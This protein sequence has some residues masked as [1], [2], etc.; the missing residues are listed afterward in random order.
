MPIQSRF[1]LAVVLCDAA[2]CS[3]AREP[4]APAPVPVVRDS[5]SIAYAA[6]VIA[7]QIS[8]IFV[9]GTFNNWSTT[10]TP[11]PR[12]ADGTWLVRLTAAGPQEY[13]F[14]I[15]GAWI[16]DMCN[17]RTWGD[18][19]KD[20]W[21]D[22]GALGCVSDGFSGRNAVIDL[23]ASA[24][25]TSIGFHHDPLAAAQLSIAAGQLSV[26]FTAHDSRVVSA[27]LT[28]T[29]QSTPM[30]KQLSYRLQDVWRG[31]LREGTTSYSISVVT[32]SGTQ[33]FG[34][35][36]VPATPFRAVPWVGS[37]VGYQIFP[38]RFWNGD[39]SNDSLTV[40]TDEIQFVNPALRGAPPA[41]SPQWNGDATSQLC[42]HQYYGGDLQGII[43]KLAY[44]Q[45]LGVTL[46][47]LNPIFSSGSAHGYDTWD[48]SQV[49][50]SFGTE[51]VLRTL[52]QQAHARGMRVMFDFV[53]NHVGLGA[54]QFIDAVK[55]G[56][57]SPTWNWFTFKAQ[58]PQL[59]AGNASQYDTF[60]GAGSLPKLNTGNSAVRDHLMAA[61]T[62]WTQFGFDGIRVDVPNEV[63][64]GTT[65]FHTFRQ[66][67]KAINPDTYLVGE[68]W[69]RAPEWV[70]G[71]KFDALMNYAIGQDVIERYARGDISAATATGLM[72]QLFAEYPEA[73]AAMAFNV[74]STHDNA[75][76]LTKL[77][78]GTRGAVP[79]ADAIAKQRLA[80]AMLYAMPG[81]PVTFQGDECAFL[82]DGGGGSRDQNRYPVQWDACDQ[83]M[84][85]HYRALAQLRRDLP[86]LAS[87]V[88]RFGSASGALLSFFR[89]E[90]G[91]GEVLALFNAGAADGV[92]T[93]PAGAWVDAVSGAAF[94][95]SV[96][97]ESH[98]WRYVRH[99]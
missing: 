8:S 44:L 36:A 47:Y 91:A 29:G 38:E 71:D 65:F 58:P 61:V 83:P 51:A 73:S 26:R 43:D 7:P 70:Q 55:N 96:T 45:S 50:P 12:Q 75:R 56:P 5:L 28:A 4:V 68:I 31:T 64:D 79:S 20:F 6:S 99:P 69:S 48:Y 60:A 13:K 53:P 84:V 52:L 2:G 11:L 39:R 22:V 41:L 9:A 90:S 67:A 21:V 98:G 49:E 17:D 37:A 23:G 15:N 85:A 16:G 3:A 19:N 63:T 57:A 1:L 46:L 18:P 62:K 87:P 24:A 86:A 78:G 14:V 30:L 33:T 32:S 54:P 27:T 66:T 74:I 25:A 40:A 42:C 89:G 35:Y 77:G 82:G 88:I 93:L 95:G 92:I 80:S 34:P 97:V 72:S 59:Q 10:E 94:T 81:V 76:L